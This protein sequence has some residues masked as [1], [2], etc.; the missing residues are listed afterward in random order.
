[1]QNE[2]FATPEPPEFDVRLP[3]GTVRVDTVPHPETTVEVAPM[4]DAAVQILEEVRV[5]QRGGRSVLVEVPERRG[6]GFLRSSPEFDIRISCPHGSSLDVRTASADLYARG[7]LGDVRAKT[8][9]GD[10]EL[11]E[12]ERSVDVQSASGDVA[13]RS[14]GSAEVSTTSGDVRM[15]TV[16]GPVRAQL[17]SGDLAVGDARASVEATT[18]SGDQRLDA[19]QRG[20]ISLRAVS[21]DI[22]VA[23][24]RGARVWLDVRSMSG[25][26]DSD[27]EMTGEPA[28]GGEAEVELRVNTVSGDVSIRRA[29]LAVEPASDDPS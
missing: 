7:H 3:A 6:F 12:V 17:V 20:V 8:A 4:N 2:V 21:G 10:V 5:E 22:S 16:L 18:V 27:L 24:R 13:I 29:G 26:T 9:S 23:V 15:D 14:A 11:D 19:V 1:M 28:G 25:D